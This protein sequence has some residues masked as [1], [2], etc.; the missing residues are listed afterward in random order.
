M[1]N[2]HFILFLLSILFSFQMINGYQKGS[3]KGGSVNHDFHFKRIP[4]KWDEGLPLGNGMLGEL[5]WLKGNRLR[6]ALD[7]AD[8]WDLRASPEFKS[9]DYRFEW[10]VSQVMKN[11]YKPVQQLLDVPYDRDATPTKIPAGAIEFDLPGINDVDYANLYLNNAL[12]E[13]KLKNG[14]KLT[15]FVSAASSY[16]FIKIEGLDKEIAPV[17]DPPPFTSEKINS[18]SNS[19]PEGNDLRRLGY[20]EPELIKKKNE[21][22]YKQK[23]TGGFEFTIR[24]SWKFIGKTLYCIWTVTTT[25]PYPLYKESKSIAQIDI[26][27]PLF[28]GELNRHTGWWKNFWKQSLVTV[29]DSILETQWYRELYKFGS[30]SRKGAPPITLQAVWTADN[31]RLPPWKGDFHNDLNT[32]LSYW[33]SYS[34][35]HLKEGEVFLDWL[36][37]NRKTALEYTKTYFGKEGL[38]FP[39][40][41][42]I[43]GDAMGGWIQYSLSP[44]VSAWLAHHFYL[45]WRYSMDKDFLRTKAYPWIKQ[46]AQFINNL[47]V[48]V[49]G[50]KELPLSSSPEIND[51]S[52]N[53]WFKETTNYDLALIRWLYSAAAEMADALNNKKEAGRWREILGQWPSLAVE[54]NKLLVAPGYELKFSHRHFSHLMAIHPLGILDWENKTDRLVIEGSLADLERLGPGQWCGYSYSWLASMYARDMNGAKA[55]EALRIF[56]TCFCSPN[57]F[58]LNGDQSKT[59]KSSFTYRPFTLEGNFAFAEG[60]QEM[61]IQ[62]QN[63]LV[64]IFPALPG[65]WKNASFKNLRAEGAFVISAGMENGKVKSVIINPEQGGTIVLRNPFGNGRIKINGRFKQKEITDSLI[66]IETIK[67]GTISISNL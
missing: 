12:A 63:G 8:L 22:I 17:I 30:T 54:N 48:T 18:G 21:I 5:I 38:D 58:H 44:T 36:L 43:N 46:C 2:L 6:F 25:K 64:K 19:G 41:A 62:S 42:T 32:Q 1:K 65:E 39:G 34:S 20:P 40:V 55:S 15:S 57:S 50:K 51:N 13:I 59:G 49:N 29:P 16:G 23:G 45:Q 28:A 66:K 53:A 56:A 37:L 31:R 9:P 11:D 33:P 61:L 52:I 60:L 26:S 4:D 27:A 47:S 3:V 67:G 35:N 14:I 7:R 10:V 24:T